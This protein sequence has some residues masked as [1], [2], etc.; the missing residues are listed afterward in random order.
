MAMMFGIAIPTMFCLISLSILLQ[1]GLLHLMDLVALLSVAKGA[2]RQD[3]IAQ[4]LNMPVEFLSHLTN[5]VA[6][7]LRIS[8]LPLDVS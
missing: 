3:E 1:I 7:W 6:R 4:F 8:R 5:I 2:I